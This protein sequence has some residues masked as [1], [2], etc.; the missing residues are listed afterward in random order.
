MTLRTRPLLE[1]AE[2]LGL[3]E[4]LRLDDL[5]RIL[6]LLLEATF[7]TKTITRKLLACRPHLDL[8]LF[9]HENNRKALRFQRFIHSEE[10]DDKK[11]SLS[12]PP[13][14]SRASPTSSA[15]SQS[16]SPSSSSM[17]FH[18]SKGVWDLVFSYMYDAGC[19]ADEITIEPEVGTVLRRM[20]VRFQNTQS[21]HC[22]FRWVTMPPL[23]HDGKREEEEVEGD[24][25]AKN[26]SPSHHR[27]QS[28]TSDRSSQYSN[29]IH[30]EEDSVFGFPEASGLNNPFGSTQ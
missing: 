11:E 1:L 27:S 6:L 21:Q 29:G 2:F 12:K 13:K 7:L 16:P 19:A 5:V 28:T 18:L 4:R 9:V 15:S 24:G 22:P 10:W 17:F 3:P 26:Q 23:S 20:D 30:E 8:V 14:S 25:N